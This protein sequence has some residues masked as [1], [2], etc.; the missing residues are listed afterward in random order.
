MSKSTFQEVDKA[1]SKFTNGAFNSSSRKQAL[2]ILEKHGW[3]EEE[4][5]DKCTDIFE[6]KHK[7]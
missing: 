6:K 5:I 3:T 7:G 1:L 2:K 4:Y